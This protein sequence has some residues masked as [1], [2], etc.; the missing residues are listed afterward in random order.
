MGCLD[1]NKI[2]EI[3]RLKEMGIFNY[4]QIGDSVG[5]SKTTVGEILAR[6][7][8]S[9][10]S[11]NDAVTMTTERLNELIYPE[12]FGR[13]PTKDEPEW[14]NIYQC[15]LKNRCLNLQYIWEE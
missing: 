15:L 4:R 10:L 8:T 6:C 9:N 1:L 7:K 14:E 3:L 12:S 13:K 5:C 2:T 11:Y